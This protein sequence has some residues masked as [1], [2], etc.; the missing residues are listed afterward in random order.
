MK[1]AKPATQN[2]VHPLRYGRVH[3]RAGGADEGVWRLDVYEPNDGGKKVVE[4]RMCLG[5]EDT[6]P[7]HGS[8]TYGY[9]EEERAAGHGYN[10][11]CASCWLGAAHTRA[12]H[13]ANIGKPEEGAKKS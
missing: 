13:D 5:S 11:N 8:M 2:I 6:T 10:A 7:P 1:K 4:R 9:T 3:V 12:R